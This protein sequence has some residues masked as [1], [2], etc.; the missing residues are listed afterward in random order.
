VREGFA[1]AATPSGEAHVS[2]AP[3]EAPGSHHGAHT[4]PAGGPNA[5]PG[6]PHQGDPAQPCVVMAHCTAAVAVLDDQPATPCD[7]ARMPVAAVSEVVP[8]S[9]SAAPEL[10]PPRA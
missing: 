1:C 2:A 3:T 9:L 4:D 6:T 5:V 8:R 10:P 7:M